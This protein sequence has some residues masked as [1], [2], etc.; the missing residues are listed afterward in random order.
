MYQNRNVVMANALLHFSIKH[1]VTTEQ[2]ISLKVIPKFS[3]IVFTASLRE[4]L[5]TGHAL[6]YSDYI[7]IT[8]TARKTP[9]QLGATL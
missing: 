7:R 6:L 2:S 4:N 3:A 1:Q 5:K 9:S 8:K